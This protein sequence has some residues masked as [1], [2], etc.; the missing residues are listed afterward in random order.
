[1]LQVLRRNSYVEKPWKNG[2][3]KTLEIALFPQG[4]SDQFLWRLSMADI[5]ASG[6]F[7]HFPGIDRT[8]VL[9]EGPPIELIHKDQV[10]VKVKLLNYLEPYRFD[11][12]IA[13][14]ARVQ[15]VG[16]DFNLM[17]RHGVTHSDFKILSL[18][19][20]QVL[21]LELSHDYMMVF[22][23]AGQ[24][25]LAHFGAGIKKLSL[26]RYDT[27]LFERQ[28]EGLVT[29]QLKINALKSEAQFIVLS[30]DLIP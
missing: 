4:A 12:G 25:S 23:V 6:P 1:M 26:D 9:L 2:Q 27:L 14:E 22:C 11:G 3:G 5:V 21:N 30:I 24:L 7:S 20:E 15:G 28:A 8:L 29:D 16:R 10:P 13:T 19:R 18:P 17:C